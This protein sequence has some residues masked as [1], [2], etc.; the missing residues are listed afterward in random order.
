MAARL[1]RDAKKPIPKPGEDAV[2]RGVIVNTAS[3]AAF[4]GQ[5]G[6]ISYSASKGGIVGMTLPMA[7]CVASIVRGGSCRSSKD[8]TV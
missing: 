4:E 5:T 8:S 2:D 6:Q 3:A 1:V 7:R